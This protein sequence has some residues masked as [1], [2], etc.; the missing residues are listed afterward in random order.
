[1]PA[2]PAFAGYSVARSGPSDLPRPPLPRRR[3]QNRFASKGFLSFAAA[4]GVGAF[5]ALSLIG[6]VGFYG[7][8]RGG[9][10]QSFVAAN[11]TVQDI[12]AKAVGFDIEAVTIAGE[13]ELSEAEILQVA[14]ISPR[15]SLLFLD[16]NEVRSRLKRVALVKDANIRKLYPNRLLIELEERQP[17][18]LWQKDGQVH[19]VAA[20]GQ[21]IDDMRDDRFARLP[22]VVG[23][24]ANARIGDYL[25]ILEVAGELRSRIRAGMFIAERRWNLKLT[26]G[27]EIKLPERNP[28]AALATLV[29]LQRESRILDK[30]VLS[31][32]L[33]QP[34]RIVARLSDEAANVRAETLVRKTRG[35]KGAQI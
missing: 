11:G 20:D 26:N 5:L 28:Q 31:L 12:L 15:N 3:R 25:A 13:R 17:F 33:R 2:E 1:V 21:P 19:I 10:Y 34:G 27:L 32:D 14:G 24:G 23:N 4:R 30:D 6:G 9:Q 35:G 29:Q 8:V 7:A 16:V 18:A 22:L